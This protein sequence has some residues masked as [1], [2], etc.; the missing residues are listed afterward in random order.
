MF[1]YIGFFS[2]FLAEGLLSI[3]ELKN[4]MEGGSDLIL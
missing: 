3:L 4:L 2:S 1:H